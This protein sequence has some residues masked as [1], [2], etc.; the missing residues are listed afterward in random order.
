MIFFLHPCINFT[1]LRIRVAVNN[2]FKD[3]LWFPQR[4]GVLER[5]II[6]PRAH[7]VSLKG[8]LWFPKPIWCPLKTYYGF[9]SPSSV[10]QKYIMV[11]RAYLVALKA[12]VQIIVSICVA[13]STIS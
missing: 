1:G 12:I 3:E 9:Q 2:T 10:L 6:V 7:R 5:Y 4:S 13:K 11:P 8:I